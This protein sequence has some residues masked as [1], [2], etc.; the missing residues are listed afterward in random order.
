MALSALGENF[1]QPL[2]WLKEQI[3]T[4]D[5]GVVSAWSAPNSDIFTTNQSI[6][7]LSKLSFIDVLNNTK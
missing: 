6:L 1:E 4:K 3:N 2:I 7:A 5:N